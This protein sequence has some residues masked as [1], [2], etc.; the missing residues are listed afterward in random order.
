MLQMD[1]IRVSIDKFFSQDVQYR[2]PR[3]QRRYVWNKTNWYTLWE[4]IL[5]QLGLGLDSET[6]REIVSK[7]QAQHEDKSDLAL[8]NKDSGHFTGLLV[9]RSINLDDL[10]RYEVIDGQQRLTTFQIILCVIRD[11]CQAKK[12][13]ELADEIK[14]LIANKPTVSRRFGDATYKFIPTNYDESA[15]QAVVVEKYGAV[16]PNAFDEKVN[17]LMPELKNKIRDQVFEEPEKVSHSILDAYDYFY[18]WIRI[19]IGETCEYDKLVTIFHSLKTQFFVVPI[20]LKS[21]RS[22]KIFESLNAT[23]RK[24]SEFDYLRNHLFLRAARLGEVKEKGDFYGDSYSDMFYAKYWYFEK[25][26]QDWDVDELEAFFQAFLM[27]NWGLTVCGGRSHLRCI[28]SI[29]KH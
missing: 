8:E 10:N 19:Y 11:I 24:L 27:A 23:G 3:Y 1:A 26:S 25:E 20:Q 12:H 22:E 17:R 21:G 2:I 13:P 5:A 4:D 6:D 9:T 14:D 29:A 18:E 28:S 16:I 7:Q 15:F